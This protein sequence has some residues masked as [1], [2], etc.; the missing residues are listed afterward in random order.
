MYFL[1]RKAFSTTTGKEEAEEKRE[2]HATS[3][4]SD[5]WMQ[6]EEKRVPDICVH[7]DVCVHVVLV[8]T[9][10]VCVYIRDERGSKI[11][12]D[13]EETMKKKRQKYTTTFLC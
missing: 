9:V 13:A 5:E 6:A 2:T 1:M 10:S 4:L 8:V 7:T 12:C 11:T 3:I